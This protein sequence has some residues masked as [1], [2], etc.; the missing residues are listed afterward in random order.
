MYYCGS[1][2]RRN[3]VSDSNLGLEAFEEHGGLAKSLRNSERNQR[4][5]D[6]IYL[7]GELSVT[8]ADVRKNGKSCSKG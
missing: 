4:E 8:R 2:S 1:K 5:M 7:E 3:E 6:K